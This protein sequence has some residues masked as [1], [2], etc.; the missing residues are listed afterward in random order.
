MIDSSLFR[1]PL[2][3]S[4]C[5]LNTGRLKY[6]TVNSTFLP[7]PRFC[8]T[9]VYLNVVLYVL[10]LA[11]CGLPVGH[12]VAEQQETSTEFFLHGLSAWEQHGH[13]HG[14]QEAPNGHTQ[15]LP[16]AIQMCIY[17]ILLFYL[18]EIQLSLCCLV[19]AV[20]QRHVCH[21]TVLIY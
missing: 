13:Y 9:C 3:V 14:R 6:S 20:K 4:N 10:N 15:W 16:C 2:V 17:P 18:C 5:S 12:L 21:R 1:W 8:H 7:K 11:F 19:Y